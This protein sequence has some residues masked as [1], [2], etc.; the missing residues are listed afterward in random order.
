MRR[1][2]VEQIAERGL[3]RAWVERVAMHPDWAEPDPKPG[4]F[5]HF[6]IVPERGERILRVVV[7][8]RDK[9]RY[10]LTAHLDRGARRP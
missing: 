4:I 6:G 2:A 3:D 8:D 5:R 9:E 7:A 1:H 10:V